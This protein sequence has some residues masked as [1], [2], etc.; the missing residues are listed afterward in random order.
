M[1]R[2]M[3]LTAGPSITQLE[4]DYVADAVKNGWNENWNNYLLRLERAFADYIGVKYAMTTS[5][6]TGALHLGLKALGIKPGD[7]VIVPEITWVA[8]AST[9]TFCGATPVFA[10]IQPDTWCMDPE[11]FRKCI[12]PRTRAVM[13]VHLWGHPAEMDEITAIAERDRGHQ[14]RR[15]GSRPR[16]GLL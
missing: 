9:V 15:D 1:R 2:K 13:P 6:G 7:E 12:T 10:D 3:I 11:S 8:S 5:C 14:S 4:V 16:G